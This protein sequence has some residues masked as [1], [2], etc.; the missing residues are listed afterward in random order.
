M[1]AYWKRYGRKSS[2]RGC[3]INQIKNFGRSILEALHFIY[4][5]GLVYGHLHS[6]NILFDLEQAL[7]VKLLDIANPITGVSAKYRCYASNLKQIR[8]CMSENFQSFKLFFHFS[9]TRT[10]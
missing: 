7:P 9:D 6:G 4:D 2:G 3:D 10:L 8:V 1:G 5:N